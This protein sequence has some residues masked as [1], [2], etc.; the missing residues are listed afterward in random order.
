MNLGKWERQ[1][2][3]TS[4]PS[5][6]FKPCFLESNMGLYQERNTSWVVNW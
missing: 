2:E 6:E 4:Y 5:Q 1:A 3:K